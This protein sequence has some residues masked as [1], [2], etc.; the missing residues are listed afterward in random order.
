MARS[1]GDIGVD[2]ATLV[3]NTAFDLRNDAW[4]DG[5]EAEVRGDMRMAKWIFNRGD[6]AEQRRKDALLAHGMAMVREAWQA[7][8][9]SRETIEADPR[10]RASSA[11]RT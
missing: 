3:V 7:P 8:A 2:L 5:Q 11:R 1:A 10:D 6:E 4:H 9:F